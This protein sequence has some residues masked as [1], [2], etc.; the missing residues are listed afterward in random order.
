MSFV[1]SYEVGAY[2][3]FGGTGLKF[4]SAT[5]SV[6][7]SGLSPAGR[8]ITGFDR[9]LPGLPAARTTLV[10]VGL[11]G[12]VHVKVDVNT[13]GTLSVR[14]G[15]DTQLVASSLA[16]PVA[17][18]FH[19]NMEVDIDDTTGSARVLVT[20]NG[21][22]LVYAAASLVDTRN[23]VAATWDEVTFWAV[24]ADSTIGNVVVQ[25]SAGGAAAAMLGPTIKVRTFVPNEPGAHAQFGSR[26]GSTENY[27]N[28]AKPVWSGVDD[29]AVT[30]N[31]TSL[32]NAMDTF[33]MQDIT[34]PERQMVAATLVIVARKVGDAEKQLAPVI[35][36]G[37]TDVIG[38]AFTLTEEYRPYA[39][40]YNVL[41]DGGGWTVDRWNNIEFGYASVPAAEETAALE[42]A[43]TFRSS[44]RRVI[45]PGRP[46]FGGL[47]R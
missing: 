30:R 10:S 7:K 9:Y 28:V 33:G 11:S 45:V 6:T 21:V 44:D 22:T 27:L 16:L 31:G 15:D 38:D 36:Q 46:F 35:R 42:T 43:T 12:T 23:G 13:N 17:A 26:V 4:A 41:P 32:D 47:G 8:F 39:T 40:V 34:D 25:D 24:V 29:D 37:G 2:G 18:P 1:N 19:L 20:T 5:A 3:P 14:R